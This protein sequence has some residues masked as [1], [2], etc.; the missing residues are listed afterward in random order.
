MTQNVFEKEMNLKN[1]KIIV[2]KIDLEE[3][4]NL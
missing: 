1:V 3:A 2:S 4:A